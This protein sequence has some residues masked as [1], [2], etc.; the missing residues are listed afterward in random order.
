MTNHSLKPLWCLCV[1][2]GVFTTISTLLLGVREATAADYSPLL[3]LA[4]RV[5]NKNPT[6][7][8]N[9]SIFSSLTDERKSLIVIICLIAAGTP[10]MVQNLEGV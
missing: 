4:V 8:I 2:S 7:N 10:Y 3:G 1:L 9:I 5:V 6:T